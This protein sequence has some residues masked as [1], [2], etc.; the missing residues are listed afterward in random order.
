M[1]EMDEKML[2]DILNT[3]NTELIILFT[4]NNIP[5]ITIGKFWYNKMLK[6]MDVFYEKEN[7]LN[8]EK[9]ID[10]WNDYGE[11]ILLEELIK[12][13]DTKEMILGFVEKVLKQN[14]LI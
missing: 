6:S 9:I 4:N 12:D 3:N 5:K 11:E 10:F 7:D 13:P 14:Y 8:K 2:H 1:G